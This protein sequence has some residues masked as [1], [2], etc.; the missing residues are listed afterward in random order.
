MTSHSC[1][2]VGVEMTPMALAQLCGRNTVLCMRGRVFVFV[3]VFVCTYMFVLAHAPVC[4]IVHGNVIAR[5]VFSF[6]YFF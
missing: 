6:L 2:S 5:V 4:D 3:F 1:V